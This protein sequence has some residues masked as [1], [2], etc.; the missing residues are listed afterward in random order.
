MIPLFFFF[1]FLVEINDSSLISLRNGIQT[2]KLLCPSLTWPI[3][4]SS[5][6]ATYLSTGLQSIL[7]LPRVSSSLMG[8]DS[9]WTIPELESLDLLP[10]VPPNLLDHSSMLKSYSS[11]GPTIIYYL[12]NQNQNLHFP[13]PKSHKNR[14]RPTKCKNCRHL[15][16][17]LR[18]RMCQTIYKVV[19]TEFTTRIKRIT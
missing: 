5:T 6:H 18:G 7:V 12:A 3:V 15:C 4:P 11:Q 8:A 1:F 13:L 9:T 2:N 19:T 16:S 14:P 10:E 17:S